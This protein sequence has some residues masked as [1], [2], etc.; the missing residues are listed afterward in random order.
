M[1]DFES[2]QKFVLDILD[3]LKAHFIEVERN[4]KEKLKNKSR[5]SKSEHNI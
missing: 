3:E 4:K 5:E 2:K 1:Y